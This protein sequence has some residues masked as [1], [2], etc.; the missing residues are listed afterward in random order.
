GFA[1]YNGGIKQAAEVVTLIAKRS[2]KHDHNRSRTRAVVTPWHVHTIRNQLVI[3]GLIGAFQFTAFGRKRVL[4]L[5]KRGKH[6]L[7]AINLLVRV[8]LDFAPGS[9]QLSK[10]QKLKLR[11]RDERRNR[12]ELSVAGILNRR[13]RL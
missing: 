9:V 10:P 8:Q 6:I 3:P 7:D 4:S 12:L 11:S 13:D 2:V 5:R 1:F